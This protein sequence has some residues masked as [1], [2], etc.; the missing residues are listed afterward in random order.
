MNVAEVKEL[1]ERS[2]FYSSRHCNL[3]KILHSSE[4]INV[5]YLPP[6]AHF[7][8][9]VKHRVHMDAIKMGNASIKQILYSDFRSLSIPRVKISR[10]LASFPREKVHIQV[11][12]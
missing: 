8:K 3:S 6:L 7:V 2:V 10:S 1:Q 12:A 5:T 9:R 11:H 4:I